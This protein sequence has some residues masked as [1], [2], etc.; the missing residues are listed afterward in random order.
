MARTSRARERDGPLR[1]THVVVSDAFAG[2]ERYICDVTVELVRRGHD[3]AVV[4]G[5]ATTMRRLLEERA[6][7]RPGHGAGQALGSLVAG[8]RRDLVHTHETKADFVGAASWPVVGGVQVSTRHILAPRGSAPAA[9]RLAPLVRRR[10]A[11]EIAVSEFVAAQLQGSVT[12]VVVNG[13]HS[14]ADTAATATS[15]TVLVA[16]RLEG[17]KATATALQAWARTGLGER[18]WR[19]QVA[20]AG[21]DRSELE[22]LARG[23]GVVASVDFLGWVADM[24]AL[25]LAS[26]VFLATA[27]AEPLGLSV[28]EAMARGLPVVA[29][30]AAGHRETVGQVGAAALFQPGDDA[31]CALQILR[32]AQDPDLRVSYGRELADLQRSQLSIESH[33]DGLEAVY[34][35]AC[36][37]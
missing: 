29:T 33:V 15:R 11:R 25:Y 1:I 34:R 20:G 14:V 28:L 18:G 30:D 17:E 32:L 12:D 4:G 3:L 31:A 6:G 21:P 36:R 35:R 37:G 8:G 2:T 7:W 9:R 23:L 19:L 10:I 27:P 13:V 5:D 22:A 24:P 26:A 16:Q